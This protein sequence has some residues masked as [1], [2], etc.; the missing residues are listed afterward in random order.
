MT[1]G[2]QPYL[3]Y[4]VRPNISG[5]FLIRKTVLS[6]NSQAD[7]VAAAYDAMTVASNPNASTCLSAPNP[8]VTGSQTVSLN[9]SKSSALYQDGL[10][11]IRVNAL[12]GLNLIKAF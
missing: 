1:A 7:T 10:T 12:Y 2:M 4:S 9:A 5:N 6:G 11:E 3:E 8:A